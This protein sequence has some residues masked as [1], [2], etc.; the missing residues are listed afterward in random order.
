MSRP[1]RFQGADLSYHVMTRGNNKM[2]IFLDDLDYARFLG[3]LGDVVEEFELDSWLF[4]VMPNHFHLVFR[5]RRPNLSRAMRQLNGTYAQWWNRRH[6]RVGHVYQGRFKAQVIEECTYLLRLCRY[7]L[8]NPVRANLV[9][10]PWGWRWSSYHALAG[11]ERACVDVP[12][13]LR[14]IDPDNCETVRERLLEYVENYADDEIA[15]FLRRDRRVIGSE[16]FAARF[17]TRA[18]RASVQVPLRERQ[19]GT[20][21]LAQLLAAALRRGHGLPGGIREAHAALYRMED[22]ATCAGVALQTVRRVLREQARGTDRSG[23]GLGSFVDLTPGA[24]GLQT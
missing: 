4:C 19:I 22:I 10:S 1:I 18:R 2:R 24:T 14:A 8:M 23:T 12:S 9:A 13:L 3:I 11:T 5:T 15:D 6:S 17:K 21:P 16:E 20:E 7:V